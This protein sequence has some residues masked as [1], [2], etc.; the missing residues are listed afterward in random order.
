MACT[1]ALQL[2]CVTVTGCDA[3]RRAG[4]CLARRLERRCRTGEVVAVD[5]EKI[6]ELVPVLLKQRG[7]EPRHPL[8]RLR[9]WRVLDREHLAPAARLEVRLNSI[10][11]GDGHGVLAIGEDGR[12]DLA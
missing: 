4:R 1:D 5:A 10:R 2:G 7:D 11:L 9:N 6:V 3:V 8:R 12:A